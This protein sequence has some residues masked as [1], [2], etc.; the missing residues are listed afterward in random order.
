MVSLPNGCRCSDIKVSPANW[1]K[2]GAT[3]NKPWKIH[4]RFYDPT[5]SKPHQVIIK[6]GINHLKDLTERRLAVNALI[7][8]EYTRL[9][10]DGYNP[11]TGA[12]KTDFDSSFELNS[13]MPLIE[14]LKSAEKNLQVADNTRK[15][16]RCI[17][18][19][20]EKVAMQLNL[21][22]LP[23]SQ[24]S[25]KHIKSILTKLLENNPSWSAHR[26]NTYRSY[27]Q[28]LFLELG[29]SETVSGNPVSGIKKMKTVLKKRKILN[30]EQRPKI[31]SFLNKNDPRFRLFV[32][33]F[34]HS[35]GRLSE[36]VRVKVSDVDLVKQTYTTLIKKGR[37]YYEASRTIKDI[38]IP[39][40]KEYMQSAKPNE[41]LVGLDFFPAIKP[42]VT[43][44][45]TRRW[46]K[47]VKDE[48]QIDI[49]LYSLKHLNTT[50][51][52]PI[53]GDEMAAGQNAQKSTEMVA[54]VYDVRREERQHNA[55]RN[56][57]NRFA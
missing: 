38:A 13:N 41:Y 10:N 30:D 27:L 22:N 25:R 32:H 28:M 53:V 6:A 1:N 56:V 15:D 46:K 4:Y 33:M 51:T 52:A 16:I 34:F 57:A 39:F 21:H 44:T 43:N 7:R 12:L 8:Q 19:G 40:W 24:T 48:L 11:I 18:R 37:Q 36:F 50:E 9:K 42:V 5:F 35:G 29:E 45:I 31:D 17:I 55:L 47:W 14:A 23:V 2:K 54:K 20:V 49:D 26:Y 3:T